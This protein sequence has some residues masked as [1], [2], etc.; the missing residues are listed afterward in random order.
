M[1]FGLGQRQVLL[2][3]RDIYVRCVVSLL[4]MPPLELPP[5][6]I[7]C[8]ALF[9]VECGPIEINYRGSVVLAQRSADKD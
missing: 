2:P 6:Y 5:P 7:P 8:E 1:C 4:N 3:F 9:E